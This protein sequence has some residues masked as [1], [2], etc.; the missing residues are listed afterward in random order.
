VLVKAAV[1]IVVHLGV[2][3]AGPS[4]PPSL[5]SLPCVERGSL[6]SFHAARSAFL[7]FT[8]SWGCPGETGSRCT[9][10]PV[11]DSLYFS[12]VTLTTVGY[13]DIVPN[14]PW[15]KVF[16]CV[17]II[18]G[19]TGVM[20]ALSAAANHLLTKQHSV[21]MQTIQEH[22]DELLITSGE[23]PMPGAHPCAVD[24]LPLS[25]STRSA[26]RCVVYNREMI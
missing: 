11:V 1:A 14:Q 13:G 15:A 4:P 2:G 18:F 22:R 9:E 7:P 24:A 26:T 17:Y 10:N 16:V 19:L 5:L 25:C 20:Y 21:L 8:D 3:M 6:G 12:V 23:A